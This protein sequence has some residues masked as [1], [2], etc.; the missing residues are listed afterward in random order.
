MRWLTVLAFLLGLPGIAPSAEAMSPTPTPATTGTVSAVG[1][2]TW[3][4]VPFTTGFG[5][6]EE[7]KLYFGLK[8]ANGTRTWQAVGVNF[9]AYDIDGNVFDGC[10]APFDPEGPGVSD[11]IAPGE[12][13]FLVCHRSIVPVNVAELQVVA[14]VVDVHPVEGPQGGA[15][16]IEAGFEIDQA[17][18]DPMEQSY[19]PFVRLSAIRDA[20]VIVLVRLYDADHAQIG[21]CT[22]DRVFV[23]PEV[24]R[25]VECLLPVTVDTGRNQPETVRAEVYASS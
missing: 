17:F 21:T 4:V 8:V 18:S 20:H 7:G 2:P 19:V 24:V 1:D 12:T 25:R 6:E 14:R 13:A 16:A 11:S 5:N 15:A 22:T 23:Q 9:R 10:S 3:W